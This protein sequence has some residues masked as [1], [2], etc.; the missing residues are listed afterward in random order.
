MSNKKYI[1]NEDFFKIKNLNEKSAYVLGWIMSDGCIQFIPNKKYCIRF[2]LKDIEA[3]ELIKTL[4]DSTHPIR[5]IKNRNTYQLTIDSKKLV[6]QL[7]DLGITPA[8]TYTLKLPDIE[9]SLYQH[10][11]RGY[12]DGDGSVMLLNKKNNRKQLVSYICSI[13]KDFLFEIGNIIK[14]N[15]DNIIKIYKDKENF[16]KLRYGAKESFAFYKYM[17]N[18]CNYFLKRKK[19]IFEQGIEI[20]AGIGLMNCAICNKEI[21]RTSG[22]KKY[23]KDCLKKVLIKRERA[24]NKIRRQKS[25]S[26]EVLDD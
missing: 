9:H 17:Y 16:Y 7:L 6:K 10:L 2:D 3:L 18:N 8:K 11:I 21:V 15:T 1:V 26:Q 25:M 12:F 22:R 23:C 5:T 14:E 24:R 13:N 20:K 19:D 4:M